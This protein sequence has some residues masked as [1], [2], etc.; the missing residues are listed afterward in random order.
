MQR[1]VNMIVKKSWPGVSRALWLALILTALAATPVWA[2]SLE[3]L[4]APAHCVGTANALVEVNNPSAIKV[5][6]SLI[7]YLLS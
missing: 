1:I 6:F 2:D 5:V 7:E 3:S 4:R